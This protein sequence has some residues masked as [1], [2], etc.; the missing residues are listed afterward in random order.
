MSARDTS[1]ARKDP[2]GSLIMLSSFFF[3]I[4]CLFLDKVSLCNPKQALISRY[5]CLSLLSAG[6]TD[7]SRETRPFKPSYLK[8]FSAIHIE[9][10]RH[11]LTKAKTKNAY[12]II[13]IA[14][15]IVHVLIP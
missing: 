9:T 10:R 2:S 6:I 5:Y 11:I 3:F 8:C 14:I 7:V 13:T 1:P 15:R 4:Y 12:L